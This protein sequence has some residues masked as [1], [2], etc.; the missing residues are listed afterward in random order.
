[1]VDIHLQ[2]EMYGGR[3]IHYL[4]KVRSGAYMVDIHVH[5]EMYR[6]RGIHY[7]G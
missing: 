5:V 4:G 2:V 6:G 7:L 1:M 3:G